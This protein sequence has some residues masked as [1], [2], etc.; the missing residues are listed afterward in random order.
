MC[1]RPQKCSQT[2]SLV[3]ERS[4]TQGMCLILPG[5][6]FPTQDENL[7]QASDGSSCVGSR[8]PDRIRSRLIGTNSFSAGN[9]FDFSVGRSSPLRKRRL[10]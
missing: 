4:P 10:D 5:G 8:S 1:P 3:G 6:S 9:G 7:I 2:L